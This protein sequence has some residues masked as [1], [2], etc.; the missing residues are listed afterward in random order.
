MSSEIERLELQLRQTFEGE[1]WHGPSVL[2]LLRDVTPE[3]AYAHPIAGAHSIW[4]LVLHLAGTYK[5]VLRRMQGSESPLSPDE[6]W[7]SVPSPTP[8]NWQ[9]AIGSLRDLNGEVRRAVLGFSPERLDRPLVAKPAYT[10]YTQFIGIT[11]HDT[12]HGGQIALLKK[13]LSLK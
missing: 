1:A 10:A 3:S 4:E 12:Y 13:A 9:D 7:P 6:D 8:S 11:Q 2:E 5:L